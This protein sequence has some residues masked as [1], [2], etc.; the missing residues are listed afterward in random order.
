[1]HDELRRKGAIASQ[2][3]KN[4]KLH[5]GRR[6]ILLALLITAACLR[7]F[8]CA[9]YP[10]T[11]ETLIL[12]NISNFYIHH[13]LMPSHFNFPTLFSY[14]SAFATGIG[15]AGMMASAIVESAREFVHLY[16]DF[17]SA[18]PVFPGRLL[19]AL[20]GVG[21]VIVVFHTAK[22]FFNEDI[23]LLATAILGFST[24][25]ILY[26]GYAL[27]DV[28]TTFF[29]SCSLYYALAALRSETR[30]EYILAGVF[31]GLAA[32]TKYNGA[33]VATAIAAVHLI[34]LH[35]RKL[36]GRPAAWLN[37][38]VLWSGASFICALVLGSP[39]L[40][41]DP[42]SFINVFL[43][44]MTAVHTG[45]TGGFGMTYLHQITQF[46]HWEKTFAIIFALGIGAA[47][48]RRDRK[49]IVL[50]ALVLPAF[51][52]IGSWQGGSLHY[53]L[54]LYPPLALM[55]A[56]FLYVAL[57]QTSKQKSRM[58]PVLIILG[59]FSWPVYSAT[60]YAYAQIS[61]EDSRRLAYRWIQSHL[62]DGSTVVRD[63]AYLPPLLTRHD[64]QIEEMHKNGYSREF[65]LKLRHTRT[66]HLILLPYGLEQIAPIK[67][68]YLIT[69]S[70]C[71]A[72]FLTKPTPPT[73]NPLSG[74]FI[75]RKI[76]YTRML[77]SSEPLGWKKI[78][79]FDTGK[80]PRVLVF[81]RIVARSFD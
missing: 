70:Y 7:I 34:H 25:H 27:P 19:S 42:V 17:D 41:I 37:S 79:V 28:A 24:L 78:K 54:F 62:P 29:V 9:K 21:T 40:L 16:F 66:Y 63:W 47:L 32:T 53:M 46:W 69:S 44:I 15:I 43:R 75:A 8:S 67:G 77:A 72:R 36:L 5:H 10:F 49:D 74:P 64:V 26:S 59:L 76:F 51:L 65:L 81:Q 22:K 71:Y 1:M 56:S 39:G 6:W 2:K 13:T 48:L 14:L 30:R 58:M 12:E 23:A 20:M 80:G 3:I 55:A 60:A 61:R 68:D 18:L 50:L 38:K 52:Y 45:Y 31:A 33:M 73:G 57:K 4:R 35:D 11:D